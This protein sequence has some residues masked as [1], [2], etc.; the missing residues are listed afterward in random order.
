MDQRRFERRSSAALCKLFHPSLGI[1]ELK[2]RDISDGG[3]FL[4]TGHH[5][6]PPVGT[7]VKVTIKRHSGVVNEEPVDMRVVHQ[8]AAGIGLMFI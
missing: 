7:V 1:I 8:Q 3:L 5:I 6:A 4:Y 2:V